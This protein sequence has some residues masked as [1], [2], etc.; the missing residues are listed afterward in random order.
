MRDKHIEKMG[1]GIQVQHLVQNAGELNSLREG[2]QEVERQLKRVDPSYRSRHG[3]PV[4]EREESDPDS[5]KFPSTGAY[6]KILTRMLID[7]REAGKETGW[8]YSRVGQGTY[9]EVLADLKQVLA[10]ATEA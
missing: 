5:P 4:H 10:Q 1:R 7:L 9:S 3:F 6:T 2:I 8:L